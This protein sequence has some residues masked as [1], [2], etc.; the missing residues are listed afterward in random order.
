M[1]LNLRRLVLGVI[2]LSFGAALMG[3]NGADNVVDTSEAGK[4]VAPTTAGGTPNAGQK[5]GVA[6]PGI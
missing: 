3:C 6:P 5:G 2:V 1:K 4:P